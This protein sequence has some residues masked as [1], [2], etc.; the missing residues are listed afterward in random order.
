[1]LAMPTFVTALTDVWAVKVAGSLPSSEYWA[2][3]GQFMVSPLPPNNA[4][5]HQAEC[6]RTRWYCKEAT[7][8]RVYFD[9]SET[10]PLIGN[11]T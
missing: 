8:V 10:L 4:R 11:P 2:A 9:T 1:M 6:D 5:I 3:C 7:S